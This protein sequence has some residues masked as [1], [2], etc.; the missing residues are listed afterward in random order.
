MDCGIESGHTGMI[1]DPDFRFEIYQDW[2]SIRS[3]EPSYD[4]QKFEKNKGIP[5][6]SLG[7]I[8]KEFQSYDPT[9]ERWGKLR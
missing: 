2:L 5:K 6:G 4:S 8:V 3:R 1:S 9:G 7:E